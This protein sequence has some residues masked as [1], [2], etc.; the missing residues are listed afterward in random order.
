MQLNVLG[1]FGVLG[2][3]EEGVEVN[4]L[5]LTLGVDPRNFA[6]KLPLIGRIGFGGDTQPVALDALSVA[7]DSAVSVSK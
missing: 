4:V 5:G 7:S 6:I 1:A 3:L 2:G